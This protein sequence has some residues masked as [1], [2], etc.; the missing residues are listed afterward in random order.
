MINL[1]AFTKT[2][3]PLL[4]IVVELVSYC[5]IDMLARSSFIQRHLAR[6][7]RLNIQVPPYVLFHY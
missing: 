1:L 6:L 5:F 2:I 4:G 7:I 3:N